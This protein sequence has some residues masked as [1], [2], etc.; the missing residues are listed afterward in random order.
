[1]F[2]SCHIAPECCPSYNLLIAEFTL[3]N[4]NC[5]RKGIFKTNKHQS[6]NPTPKP[7][8]QGRNISR[9]NQQF[10]KT[11]R[12]VSCSFPQRSLNLSSFEKS[13]YCCSTLDTFIFTCPNY[14][15]KKQNKNFCRVDTCHAC[16]Y[17]SRCERLSLTFYTS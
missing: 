3:K 13:C 1:M 16:A 9:K 6:H 12:F 4:T 14:S 10:L 5:F 11:Y 15:T 8:L 7:I 2:E 17:L